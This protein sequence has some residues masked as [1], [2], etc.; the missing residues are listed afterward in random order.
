MKNLSTHAIILGHKNLGE[1]DKMIF[2]YSREIGKCRVIAKGARKINSKFTGHLE[3]L[4]FANVDLYFGPRNIILREIIT[5]KNFKKIRENF[6][7]T[8]SA[9]QIAKITNELLYDDQKIDELINLIQETLKHLSNTDKTFLITQSYILK[10][11]D[12]IGIIPDFKNTETKITEKYLKFFNF[13][14][15]QSLNEISKI[16]ISKVE[17]EI[18]HNYMKKFLES[19]T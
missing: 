4:N 1:N 7:K 19:A 17:Q 11:L 10:F 5:I 12:H 16:K 15:T 13:I 3:T 6:E 18:I 9:I 2:L 14:K 8:S